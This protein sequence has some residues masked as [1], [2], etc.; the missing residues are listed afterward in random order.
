MHF[1]TETVIQ[2]SRRPMESFLTRFI[3]PSKY[4]EYFR[5][6]RM[7]KSMQKYNSACQIKPTLYNKKYRLSAEI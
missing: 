5:Q 6:C 3:N 4:I 1:K 7:I 2:N